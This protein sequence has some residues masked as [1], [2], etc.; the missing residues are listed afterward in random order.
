MGYSDE[1]LEIIYYKTKGHCN[2]CDKKLSLINYGNLDG[3][4]AW[5]VD[6]TTPSSQD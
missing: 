4:G 1:K 2:I 3:K 6:Q 5:E